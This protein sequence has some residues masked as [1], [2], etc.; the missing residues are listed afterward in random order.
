VLLSAAAGATRRVRLL[1]SILVLPYHDPVLLANQTASL[2]VLS[3]GRFVL[4][5]GAGWNTAEFDA[6]GVPASERGARTDEHLE[7]LR[8][9][10]RGAAVTFDGRFTRLYGAR[11]GTAP[12]TPGGPPVWVGGSSDAALRRALRRGAGWHGT[13]LSPH[14][15]RDVRGRLEALADGGDRDPATLELSTV[16]FLAPPGLPGGVPGWG[17]PLGGEA[18]TAESVADEL[19]RLGEEG[20]SFVSL[21]LAVDGPAVEEAMAWVAAEVMP[22]LGR[23]G[24]DG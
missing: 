15:A 21:W 1:T 8:E 9:L 11:I 10:W 24:R 16:A 14:D 2:D 22:R 6:L 19:G 18:A 17:H 12:R 20:I 3:G 7:V 5:V 4:G 23:G 13:G